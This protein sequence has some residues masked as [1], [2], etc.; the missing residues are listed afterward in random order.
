M[1]GGSQAADAFVRIVRESAG[2]LRGPEDC[3]VLLTQFDQELARR[4]E[5]GETTGLVVIIEGSKI[6]GASVGDSAAWFFT[7]SGTDELTS[8]QQRK[9]LLGSGE[10]PLPRPFNGPIEQ[11]TLVVASD[12]LW[13]YT[14]TDAI[15][16]RVQTR[17]ATDLAARL[18]ELARLPSGAFPDDVAVITCRIDIAKAL[19][20]GG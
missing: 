17:K 12:G 20:N 4:N 2:K 18:A 5:C 15:R 3:V 13:K 19:F 16:S 7:G 1:S 14:S 9:P 11:G 10:A 8:G 6:F